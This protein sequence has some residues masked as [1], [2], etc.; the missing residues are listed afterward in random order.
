MFS[1]LK[2]KIIEL[3]NGLHFNYINSGFSTPGHNWK[4]ANHLFSWNRLFYIHSG[5]AEFELGSCT[6]LLQK[7]NSYLFPAGRQTAYRCSSKFSLDWLHFE[8]S[9]HLQPK[10]L[11]VLQCPVQLPVAASPLGS[12]LNHALFKQLHELGKQKQSVKI[13]IEQPAIIQLLLAPFINEGV[14]NKQVKNLQR[15]QPVLIYIEQNIGSQLR[16]PDLAQQVHL[17]V[18]YFSQLFLKVIGVSPGLYIQQLRIELACRWLL[19]TNKSVE[20]IAQDL[21][22]FDASHFCRLFKKTIGQTP[23]QY[24]QHNINPI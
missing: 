19:D 18:N 13:N 12:S 8:A 23:K 21:S 3:L 14:P 10:L 17:E 7:G 22:Y 11:D 6:Y 15:L 9:A 1:I 5:E 20:A 2:D 24:K 16:L 4:R